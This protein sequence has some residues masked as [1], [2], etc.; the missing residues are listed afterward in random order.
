M[1]NT[2]KEILYGSAPKI[3]EIAAQLIQVAL[4]NFIIIFGIFFAKKNCQ[5]PQ[6]KF[7][8]TK[9]INIDY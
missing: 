7:K 9:V 1:R 5:V 4:Q 8:K 6:Y 3:Y 2:R